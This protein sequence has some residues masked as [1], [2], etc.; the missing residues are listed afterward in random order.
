MNGMDHVNSKPTETTLPKGRMGCLVQKLTLS[1][2]QFLLKGE[3]KKQQ[4]VSC[5]YGWRRKLEKMWPKSGEILDVD[6]KAIGPGL[7]WAEWTLGS[8]YG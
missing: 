2:S 8:P 1:E 5:P 6:G 3:K 4:Q 7:H